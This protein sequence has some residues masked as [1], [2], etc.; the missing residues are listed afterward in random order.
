MKID[1][2]SALTA[3]K[4]EI[5]E[6]VEQGEPDKLVLELGAIEMEFAVTLHADAKAKGGFKALVWTA[7]V[8]GGVSRDRV[9][10]IKIAMTPKRVFINEDGSKRYEI[11]YRRI[12]R[13]PDRERA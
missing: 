4:A 11:P 7:E 6:A 10:R 2:A 3:L 1:L 12:S 8:E 5:L 9:Q 13:R